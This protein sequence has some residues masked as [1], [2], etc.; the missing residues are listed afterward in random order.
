MPRLYF[1]EVTMKGLF[2]SFISRPVFRFAAVGVVNTIIG[3]GL[4][5]VLYNFAGLSYWVSSAANY[6]CGGLL[7]YFLNR[8]FTFRV[9]KRSLGQ[10]LL[11]VANQAVCYLVAYGA[12][13]PAAAAV[14]ASMGRKT[15]ENIAML[16]GMAV[17]TALNY[18]GQKYIVFQYG[19]NTQKGDGTE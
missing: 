9:K 13:K 10:F 15:Q 18:L 2:N 17:F 4:M 12:A 3:A 5:F 6:I 1:S 8:K 11:F 16:A 7:S 14:F 19:K